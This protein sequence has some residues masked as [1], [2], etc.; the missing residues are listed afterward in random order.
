MPNAVA[1]VLTIIFALVPVKS[2][3]RPDQPV[4]IRFIQTQPTAATAKT[5]DALG[6]TDAA[7]LP[8]IFSP[9]QVNDLV[10]QAGQPE[11]ALY[12]FD[13]KAVEATAVH[14][15]DLSKGVV[16]VAAFFPQIRK[17]GTWILTWRTAQPL[18]ITTSTNPGFGQRNISYQL[19]KI[20]PQLESMPKD[21]QQ[22]IIESLTGAVCIHIEPLQYTVIT[23]DK[24]IMKA[25][26]AY[27]VAPVTV[28]NFIHLAQ[29]GFYDGSSFHR[30]IKKF[31]IQGGD[32]LE[33]GAGGGGPGYAVHRE[34]NE[35][36]H[37]R[38]T[39]SMARTNDPDS[40][41]SQFFII[42]QRGDS[43]ANLDRQYTVFGQTF[44]GL[45]VLDKI[46]ETPV[47]DDNGTVSGPKPRINSIQILPATGEM[48]GIKK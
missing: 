10:D 5:I 2:Y 15:V 42:H 45:D 46:A 11:F 29:G 38:G 44:E 40:A 27:D 13:G 43:S 7:R 30:I 33:Q 1:A 6:P 12:T 16:D 19:D 32:S 25:T 21:Q 22:K 23:S 17:E 4:N 41:G 9:A 3:V 31:M 14:G 47:S 36:P 20:R 48:Y 35:R 28:E 37:N 34:F 18:V 26:F 39:L 8:D 24:G